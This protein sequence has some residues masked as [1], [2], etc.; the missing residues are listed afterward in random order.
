MKQ[1]TSVRHFAKQNRSS[2][3]EGK[4]GTSKKMGI[5]NLSKFIRTHYKSSAAKL[6]LKSLRFKKIA[7]DTSIFMCKFK[8]TAGDDWLVSFVSM[9][10]SFRKLDIHPIFVFDNG[11]PP[12]KSVERQKR[13]DAKRKQRER[14]QKFE[15]AIEKYH[16]SHHPCDFLQKEYD[17]EMKRDG[18]AS[19]LRRDIFRID[20]MA[21][22]LRRLKKHMFSIKP[23]DFETLRNLL[24]LLGIPWIMADLEAEKTCVNL[25]HHGLA[26]AV[27][28]E[29]TDCL[30]YKAPLFLSKINLRT[31]TAEGIR[32][33][34][35]LEN[36]EFESDQFIDFCIMC[37]TDYNDNIPRIGVSKAFDLMRKYQSID[38]L[39]LD[40]S[41]VRILN[42]KAS[43]R[44]FKTFKP[45][46][47]DKIA[48][49]RF[50]RGMPQSIEVAAFLFKHN[51]PDMTREIE[52]AFG[53]RKFSLV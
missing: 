40:E 24:D 17:A 2:S 9:I 23:K 5:K 42:H 25:I 14:I 37:G 36:L 33:E 47:P 7:I 31:M 10:C 53:R 50:C 45:L 6:D 30:P 44:L 41:K 3:R 51:L 26:S 34:T 38:N 15:Q 8:A 29:D 27:M 11:A 1:L 22:K 48:K 21:D 49:I 43:R 13:D 46:P 35:L 12:E 20:V 18:G 28:S 4:H 16:D 52:D 32:F 39:P 19:L